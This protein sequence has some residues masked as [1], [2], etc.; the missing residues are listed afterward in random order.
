MNIREIARQVR[1]MLPEK[2][3]K[4]TLGVRDTAVAMAKTFD[5]PVDQA[6]LAGLLHDCAKGMDRLMLRRYMKEYSLYSDEIERHD[7]GL[8]HG[9]VASVVAAQR[10]EVRDPDVLAA[11]RYHTFGRVGMSPLECIVYVADMIEPHREFPGVLPLRQLAQSDLALA[12]IAAMEQ[13]IEFVLASGKLL[14]PATV[15]ARNV[16]LLQQAGC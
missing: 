4:H 7:S 8:W 11:I 3:W 12:T 6:E 5:V 9:P 1:A 16:L 10:F 13:S 14:H 15:H 2:R